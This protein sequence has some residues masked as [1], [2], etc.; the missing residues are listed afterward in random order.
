MLDRGPRER[1][2]AQHR[3]ARRAG[4]S[5]QVAEVIEETTAG[6]DQG[7]RGV[8]DEPAR[9]LGPTRLGEVG[10]ECAER[11]GPGGRHEWAVA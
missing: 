7:E 9:G 11:P 4:V 1:V 8:A 3:P 10:V 5:D 2:E 6:G